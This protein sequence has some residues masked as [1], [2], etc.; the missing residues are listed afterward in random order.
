MV[1]LA[2]YWWLLAAYMLYCAWDNTRLFVKPPPADTKRKKWP[3]VSILIPARNEEK[4]IDPCIR[5]MLQQDYP[6]YEILILD[7]RSTDR[8]FNVVQAYAKRNVRLKVLRG[9]ELP[10]GWVGKPWA[11]FQLSKKARG[12]WLFFT[13][14]D[15]EHKPDM[16]KRTV[17]MAEQKKAD[18]LTLFTRQITKT[19]M[20]ILVIP[21]MAYTLLA[22][23]PA[24]LSLR[25]NSRFN[26]FAGVSGQ[27]VFIQRKIYRAFGGHEVVKNEI[28][29]DLNLGKQVVRRG[30]RLVYGD[31]SDFSFCR[32]YTNAREVWEGFS[33]NFFPAMAFSPL[34]FLNAF[35]VL[36]LD[37]VLPFLAVA[38]GPSSELF[39]PGLAMVLVS[40]GVRW[41]QAVRYNY[42]KG[43]VLFHPLGCLLFA[44]IGLNSMRWFLLGGGHWKGRKL[45]AA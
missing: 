26:R 45:K 29:E 25:K 40:L 35:L 39:W 21:V 22:F 12:E 15:T 32:M 36:I 33:K 24:R 18:V 2:W 7:D 13:D 44:L 5:G 3:F 16:L 43:S 23:L 10:A 19:W 20:E 38:R 28:V 1:F 8:T 41:L 6:A 4:R 30:Y 9:K 27:F 37:G 14:A 42:H 34:Y 17:Q 31:G 11:C